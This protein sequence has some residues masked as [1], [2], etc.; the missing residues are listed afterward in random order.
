MVAQTEHTTEPTEALIAARRYLKAGLSVIPILPN[1][2]KAPALGV[3]EPQIYRERFATERELL[4]WFGPDS[5]NGV[6]LVC[7]EISGNFAVIDIETE[8]AWENW[9]ELIQRTELS[10]YLAPLPIV[11]TPKGGRHVYCRIDETWVGGFKLARKANKDTLIEVRGK[12]H[13]VLAPGCPAACHP[14]KKT[15]TFESEGWLANVR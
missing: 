15:Y 9:L 1:G 5:R 13:Y 10:A 4:K 8:K 12:G 3:D 2:T 11:R 7:G 6:G 14:L